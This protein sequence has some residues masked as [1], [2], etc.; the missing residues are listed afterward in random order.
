MSLRPAF[1]S[2]FRLSKRKLGVALAF[3]LL[4]VVAHLV[5]IEWVRH[6]LPLV[7]LLDDDDESLI[8]ITLQSAPEPPALPAPRE[9]PPLPPKAADKAEPVAAV[10]VTETPVAAVP[11]S[12]ASEAPA[13]TAPGHGEG[14]AVAGVG[15][16]G[17]KADPAE[18]AEPVPTT[19]APALFEKVS[20]PP[21]AELVYSVV[22]LRNG[23]RVTG[24]GK[25]QWQHDGQRYTVTGEVG[26]LLF[27]L[28]SYKSVGEV[29]RIGLL[30]GI[31]SEKR[32][33]RSQT[34][35]HFHRERNSISFSASTEVYPV[36]GGEQDRSTWIWQLASL[37]RGDPD[38]FEAGLVFDMSI[39]GHKSLDGWRVYVNGRENV[40]LAQ[41]T[42]STWRLSVI[43]GENSFERQ[44]DLWLAPDQHWYPVMLRHVDKAGNSVEL[45]L[46]EVK[47]GS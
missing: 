17:A 12:P 14:M 40:E 10:P 36:R 21:P 45:S 32:I 28:L 42:V 33:G 39:A 31:Y 5:V 34:N 37:G 43:P 26:V 1:L 46:A 18:A 38:K 22:G 35:T 30:P 4:T 13:D 23:R 3:L 11:E 44:F 24:H 27:T 47:Q 19:S 9:L 15:E 7:D 8:S 41:G 25:I 29:G 2:S 16:P 6:E 20:L